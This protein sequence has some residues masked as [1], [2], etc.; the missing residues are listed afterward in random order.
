MNK[1]RNEILERE[2]LKERV[3]KYSP[4]ALIFV[5][6]LVVVGWYLS[7]Q[8]DK[9]ETLV[10]VSTHHQALLHDEGHS[11]YLYVKLENREKPVR[12]RLPKNIGISIGA[13]VRVNRVYGANSSYE[14]FVFIGY[15]SDET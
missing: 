3:S 12:V 9:L 13:K 1:E 2:I 8:P 10:G 15:V 5:F 7:N 4:F 6:L 11:L 14:K